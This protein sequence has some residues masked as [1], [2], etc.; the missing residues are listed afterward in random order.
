MLP[1]LH[2][3]H[4]D[5]DGEVSQIVG[6]RTR[7]TR[8]QLKRLALS[9]MQAEAFGFD[10]EE[11]DVRTAESR[12]GFSVA[13]VRD[14]ARPEALGRGIEARVFAMKPKS[15]VE[16][17]VYMSTSDGVEEHDREDELEAFI[18]ELR[19]ASAK[20][21]VFDPLEPRNSP[22]RLDLIAYRTGL[23]NRLNVFGGMDLDFTVDYHVF[24]PNGRYTS[25]VPEDG[26]LA[27]IDWALLAKTSPTRTGVYDL[28]R[29]RGQAEARLVIR[30]PN[31]YGFIVEKEGQVAF[32]ADENDSD[33]GSGLAGA[34]ETAAPRSLKIGRASQTI[35]TRLPKT[36]LRGRYTYQYGSSGSITSSRG[37][38][39]GTRTIKLFRGGKFEA[40]SFFSASFSHDTGGGETSGITSSKA[41]ATKGRY[42]LQGY[43]LT[44]TYDD[45]RVVERFC[46][47]CGEAD[48]AMLMINESPYLFKGRR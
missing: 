19:F 23:E 17:F 15:D 41:P 39:S 4:T 9:A 46:H 3:S 11:E 34:R 5:G 30:T 36:R 37:S 7:G 42:V 12:Q 20:D 47:P 32:E 44:L 24:A 29:S 8:R 2:L 6:M 18:R 14:W 1:Y 22:H 40:T 43:T 10:V 28:V 33:A 25:A 27:G 38:A 26:N 31:R 48:D 16:V 21:P 45:G 13:Y 35:L